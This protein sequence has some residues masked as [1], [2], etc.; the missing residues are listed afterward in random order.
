MDKGGTLGGTFVN[1]SPASATLAGVTYQGS[2]LAA[3][4]G[5]RQN[6]NNFRVEGI[7]VPTNKI[8]ADVRFTRG[9]QNQKLGSYGISSA[10]RIICQSVPAAFVAVAGCAQ[11]LQSTGVNDKVTKDISIRSTFTGVLTYSFQWYGP[12]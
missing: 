8:V 11:G 5:G 1:G 9:F 10:P 4:Q 6:S 3:L 7:W 12:A 2:Q